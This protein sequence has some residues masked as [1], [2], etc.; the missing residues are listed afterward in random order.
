MKFPAVLFVLP[1]CLV[2][3]C[4][5]TRSVH[6]PATLPA[7]GKVA[8]L[9]EGGVL[10]YSVATRIA[11]PPQVIWEILTRAAAYPQWNTSVLKLTGTVAAQQQIHMVAK[12]APERTFDL[13]VS[14]FVPNQR[15]VWEDGN[16]MFLGVRTFVLTPQP[17]GTTHFG[18]EEV[19]SGIML[20][21]IKGKL[22]DFGPSFEA[23]A[24]DLRKAAETQAASAAPP[25]EAVSPTPTA[26]SEPASG[27][28]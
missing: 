17:D 6:D 14:Q 28:L 10:A 24:A 9:D 11:A 18:M 19:Y 7:N 22:P 16:M 1:I 2:A 15:M 25:A 20:R 8:R 26:A 27:G 5:T 23:W 3:A 13:S 21:M 12:V 4:S